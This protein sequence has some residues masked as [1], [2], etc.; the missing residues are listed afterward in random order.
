[1]SN[2]EQG[3]YEPYYENLIDADVA[4]GMTWYQ[5]RKQSL[6]G[7]HLLKKIPYLQVLYLKI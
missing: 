2:A 4:R 3:Y 1:M 6:F 7:L 5:D